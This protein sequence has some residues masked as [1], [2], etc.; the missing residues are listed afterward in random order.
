MRLIH[1]LFLVTMHKRIDHY[2]FMLTLTA[3]TYLFDTSNITASIT[4]CLG[5]IPG[6]HQFVYPLHSYT[7]P[8][9]C[10]LFH[11]FVISYTL[12][13]HSCSLTWF[14]ILLEDEYDNIFSNVGAAYSLT[15]WTYWRLV[16]SI[17]LLWKSQNSYSIMALWLV[18][19]IKEFFYIQ[20]M[21]FKN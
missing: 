12:P 15:E 16:S 10:H 8:L 6:P 17:L 19:S 9:A 11:T 18:D 20:T 5:P 1:N 21:K 7:F 14:G 4:C 3:R 13:I 2:I